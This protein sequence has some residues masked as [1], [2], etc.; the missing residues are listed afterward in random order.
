MGG[1]EISEKGHRRES[2]GSGS[3]PEFEQQSRAGSIPSGQGF[4]EAI[5][6]G[7]RQRQDASAKMA[8]P[9]AGLSQEEVTQMAEEYCAKYG[10]TEE[11]D[12]RLF[13]LG[14]RIAGNGFEWDTIEGLTDTEKE[15]LRKEVEHKWRSVPAKLYGVIFVCVSGYFAFLAILNSFLSR[16]LR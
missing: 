3:K 10:F 2:I 9:L 4:P 12:I 16:R 13:R 1:D 14:A 11:E 7:L 15:A 8:N 5:D 6:A